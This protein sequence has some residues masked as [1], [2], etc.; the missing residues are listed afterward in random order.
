MSKV[1]SLAPLL[2]PKEGARWLN[3]SERGVQNLTQN[4]VLPS[5]KIG[6]RVLRYKRSEIEQ[7]FRAK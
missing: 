4:G 1:E 7:K 2:K 5:I 3:L 6:T